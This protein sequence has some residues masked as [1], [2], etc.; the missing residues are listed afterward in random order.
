M[1][2]RFLDID[3][4][5]IHRGSLPEAWFSVDARKTVLE[6]WLTLRR[7][8]SA[9]AE[10]RDVRGNLQHTGLPIAPAT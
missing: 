2:Q 9:S 8:T 5:N 6:P 3:Q 10:L 1:P 7:V 4:V